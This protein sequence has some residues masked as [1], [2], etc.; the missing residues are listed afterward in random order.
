MY[1]WGFALKDI[2]QRFNLRSQFLH[3]LPPF[4]FPG[5]DRLEIPLHIEPLF[6]DRPMPLQGV[7]ACRTLH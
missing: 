2:S 5:V 3:P 4:N 7:R 6:A 1:E